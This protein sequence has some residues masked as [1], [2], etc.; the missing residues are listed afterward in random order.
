MAQ[1]IMDEE[2]TYSQAS[3]LLKRHPGSI[4]RAAA[5]GVL[6]K[7]EREHRYPV[8]LKKQVML[9][10]GKSRFSLHALNSQ[11]VHNWHKYQKE[12]EA[13]NSQ[14]KGSGFM[15]IPQGKAGDRIIPGF[16]ILPVREQ[17]T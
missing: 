10:Q 8:L 1:A 3:E 14:I 4:K 5:K 12:I 2:I 6:T 16:F 9:F 15:F 7:I 11:E 13:L 17:R